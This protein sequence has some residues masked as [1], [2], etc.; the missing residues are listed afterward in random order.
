MKAFI[1][2][3]KRK[4]ALVLDTETT[5][6]QKSDEV[7]QIG[8]ASLEGEEIFSSFVKPSRI[9]RWDQAMSIHGITPADVSDA[10]TIGE[11]AGQLQEILE[12]RC[13]AIYNAKFDLRM[14]WQS[15]RAGNAHQPFQWLYDLDYACV[16]EAY[17]VYWG[18]RSRRFG[19]Y[20]W[21]SLSNACQ[22]Q[23]VKVAGAHN[24]LNDALMT[25]ALMRAIANKLG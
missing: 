12:G 17:A 9:R 14:L 2:D 1:D 20:K 25:A 8:I 15:I 18:Q 23:G 19:G 10:P 24:A 6:L 5:G 7:L 16:M 13:L 11:L 4:N 21:Q 3:L 22:Q